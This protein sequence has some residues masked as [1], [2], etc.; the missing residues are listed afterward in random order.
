MWSRV[1]DVISDAKFFCKLVM[2]FKSYSLPPPNAIFILKAHRSY[3]SVSTT[4]LHYDVWKWMRNK[5]IATFLVH[6]FKQKKNFVLSIYKS[7]VCST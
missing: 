2:V 6:N 4:V 5:E 1:G 3:I 7:L